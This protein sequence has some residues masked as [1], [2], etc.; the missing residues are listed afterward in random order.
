[1]CEHTETNAHE[2]TTVQK[3][4][5]RITEYYPRIN[6]K[7]YSC[8]KKKER[9]LHNLKPDPQ[10]AVLVYTCGDGGTI[11][12]HKPNISGLSIH[13]QHTERGCPLP[14]KSSLKG[15]L[16]AGSNSAYLKSLP[17]LLKN[18]KFCLLTF[19]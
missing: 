6:I 8:Q 2:H 18:K 11:C 3:A 12:I 17:L 9:K 14:A 5:N 7:K 1:M 13:N 15:D 10:K 16:A 4:S 19:F